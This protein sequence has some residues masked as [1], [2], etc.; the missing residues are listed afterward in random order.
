MTGP[1]PDQITLLRQVRLALQQDDLPTAIKHLE[2]TVLLAQDM[3]DVGAEGRHLGNLALLHYR[4]G[5]HKRALAHFDKAVAC[6][7]A[8]NDSVTEGGLLGNMGNILR[9][10]QRYDLAIEYLDRALHI[11]DQ[12]NDLR[13][14]GIWLSNLGLVYD[15]LGQPD[16]AIH[17]HIEAV[18]VAR[19]LNDQRGLASRLGNLGNSY[20]SNSDYPQALTHF[21]EAVELFRLLGDQPELALRLGVMGNLHSEMARTSADDG[22]AVQH[23]GQA[24]QLYAETLSIARD[25]GDRVTEAH[26]MHSIGNVLGSIG[27]YDDAIQYFQQAALLFD[28]LTMAAN[29]EGSRRSINMCMTHRDRVSE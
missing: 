28:A 22:V 21:G 8:D 7:R 18:T 10:I 4:L 5:N 12:N 23:Y 11:A 14:R 1:R 2:Q 9:E 17:Y 24:L 25:L 16:D 6:A 19:D 29:A 13:G 3:G 15:D 26:L 27:R 20:V